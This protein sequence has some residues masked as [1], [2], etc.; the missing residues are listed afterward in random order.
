MGSRFRFLLAYGYS[1]SLPNV[2]RS[3]LWGEGIVQPLFIA[4][5]MM[6]DR[7]ALVASSQFV[8]VISQLN[9]TPSGELP[10]KTL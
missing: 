5:S 8:M 10:R 4:D 3:R 1:A 9:Y 7:R 2:F 6:T